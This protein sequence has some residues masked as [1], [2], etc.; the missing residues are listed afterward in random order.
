MPFSQEF[1]MLGAVVD[2]TRTAEGVVSVCNKDSRINDIGKLVEDLCA[3]DMAPMSLLETLKGRL[4]YAAGHTFGRRNQLTI[5]LVS[6]LARR[7]PMVVMDANFKSVLR[8]AF[9]SLSTAE[10][11]RVE[12]WSARWPVIVFTDGACEEDGKVVTHGQSSTTQRVKLL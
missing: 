2:L 12:A 5:Q 1:S 7:G 6:R 11:R 10:P 8:A 9:S 3:R 4:L